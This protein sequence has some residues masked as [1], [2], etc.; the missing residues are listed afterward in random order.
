[1]TYELKKQETHDIVYAILLAIYGTLLLPSAEVEE[2]G[3]GF[4]EPPLDLIGSE[5]KQELKEVPLWQQHYNKPQKQVLQEEN[6]RANSFAGAQLAAF[7]LRM[8]TYEELNGEACIKASWFGRETSNTLHIYMHGISSSHRQ[9]R[10]VGRNSLCAPG[11][12]SDIPQM[13][14]TGMSLLPRQPHPLLAVAAEALHG[15]DLWP[16]LTTA[17]CPSVAPVWGTDPPL[18]P[19]QLLHNTPEESLLAGT[20]GTPP[21][22][23]EGG[24]RQSAVFE[25]RTKNPL[26][27]KGTS[28]IIIRLPRHTLTSYEHIFAHLPLLRTCHSTPCPHNVILQAPCNLSIPWAME[29]TVHSQDTCRGLAEYQP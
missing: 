8:I 10:P 17:T 21:P 14:Q 29:L 18:E 22:S 12:P 5:L 9:R 16:A 28:P 6:S 26:A 27:D 1:M 7:A 25:A 13:E 4:T 20:P 24:Q 2:Y 23:S 3:V 11:L 15:Q 19:H